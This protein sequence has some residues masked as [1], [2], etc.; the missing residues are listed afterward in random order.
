MKKFFVVIVC[1]CLFWGVIPLCVSAKSKTE[2]DIK[3]SGPSTMFYTFCDK[4]YEQPNMYSVI[5][6]YGNDISKKYKDETFILYQKGEYQKIWRYMWKNV[7]Y[8]KHTEEENM[9]LTRSSFVNKKVKELY[10][11]LEKNGRHCPN[12][13]IQYSLTATYTYNH[14]TGVI[15]GK[16][17][18][19]LSI[20]YCSLS[21][22]W[23]YQM[24]NV[25]TSATIAKDKYSI[26]FRGS[27]KLE[28]SSTA[29]IGNIGVPLTSEIVGPYTGVKTCYP[30]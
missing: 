29:P 13:E 26:T 18:P 1:L 27:F 9:N 23:S 2:A 7:S 8:F 4:F 10:Y 24:E 22:V 21:G 20:T 19:Y 16:S 17:G 14:N 5:D 12:Y 28:V 11:K 6:K 15:T 25:V 30:E 3:E